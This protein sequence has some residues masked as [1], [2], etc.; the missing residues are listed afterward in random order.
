MSAPRSRVRF[1][2][3][4]V[5]IRLLVLIEPQRGGDGGED[6]GGRGRAALLKAGVVVHADGRQLRN[7]FAA[8]PRHLP[9]L[10]GLG[11]ADRAGCQFGPA[12]LE[13]GAHLAGVTYRGHVYH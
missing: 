3:D 1:A 2:C 13:E 8:Q 7:L 10:A 9:P 11:Q 5:Q 4:L 6:G 12:C